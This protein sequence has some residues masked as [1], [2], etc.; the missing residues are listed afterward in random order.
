MVVATREPRSAPGPSPWVAFRRRLLAS[1]TNQLCLAWLLFVA[2]IAVLAPWLAPYD[3]TKQDLSNV[4]LPPGS[5]GH[6]FGTDNLGR[7][8]LSRVLYGTRISSVAPI[9]SVVVTAG[10]G[11]PLGLAAGYLGRVTDWVTSRVADAL[12]AIPTLL[13]AIAIIAIFGPGL[14]NAMAAIG[15]AT[16]PRLFRLTRAATIAV[17][18]ETYIEASRMLGCSTWRIIFVHVLPNVRSPLLVQAAILMSLAFLSEAGL[19]FLGLGVQPPD[20]SWGSLLR[21]AFE[22]QFRGQW[23]L[24]PPAVLIV[25]TILALNVLG[26]GI[27]DAVGRGERRA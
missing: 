12:I 19:S 4:Y 9:I 1:R 14:V 21:E 10:L 7:D 6:L 18:E 15:I 27:R 20:A 22:Y 23:L 3:P 2:L 17:R 11:I 16:A 25:L 8:Y 24:V 5:E 13:L 26:D